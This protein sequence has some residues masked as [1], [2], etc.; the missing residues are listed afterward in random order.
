MD[1]KLRISSL[2][3]LEFH[4]QNAPLNQ[5]SSHFGGSCKF[6]Y[7][8]KT[9]NEVI[10]ALFTDELPTNIDW[11][12]PEQVLT[13]K[14]LVRLCQII[15]DKKVEKYKILTT[16]TIFLGWLQFSEKLITSHD[17]KDYSIPYGYGW[18]ITQLWEFQQ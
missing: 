7:C 14:Q 9:C 16:T 3:L 12:Y 4:K 15:I 1:R 13:Q 2:E 11:A 17:G 6:I 5:V 10:K 8:E 18:N